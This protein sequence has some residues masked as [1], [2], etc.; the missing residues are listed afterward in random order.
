MRIKKFFEFFESEKFDYDKILRMIRKIHGWGFGVIN[1]IDDFESNEEYYK[2][3]ID[4]NDYVEQFHIYLTDLQ[5][6]K[7]RGS[8]DK[9]PILNTGQWKIGP[10]VNKPIS[11]WSQRM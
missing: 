2:N 9:R 8:F 1:Y 10:I 7:L 5:S 6:K 11:I 3:P 4:A